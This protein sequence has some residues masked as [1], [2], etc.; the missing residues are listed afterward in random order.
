MIAEAAALGV[1]RQP[2]RARSCPV[3]ETAGV[4]EV[5]GAENGAW[6]ELGAPAGDRAR[7]TRRC[8]V[9]ARAGEGSV[10]LLADVSPLQNRGL[11]ARRQRGVRARAGRRRGTPVAF[12]ETVHGY[13][14]S[15]GFGGLP[16]SVKWVLLGL[17]LTALV[18]LWAAG[19]RF[20]PPEDAET[21]CRR[22]ASSTS[23]RSPPRSCAAKPDKEDRP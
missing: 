23:T 7:R 14:V 18:A 17:A 12:L 9:T 3:A 5:R 22:R 15:R 4:E 2:E 1:R 20:G 21:R 16:A 6:H 8:V 10:A 11:D 13:G 19:R